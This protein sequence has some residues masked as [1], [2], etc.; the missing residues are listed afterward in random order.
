MARPA[1]SIP[2]PRWPKNKRYVKDVEK[3]TIINWQGW[4]GVMGGKGY[5]ERWDGEPIRLR[6]DDV[7]EILLPPKKRKK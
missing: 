3:G 1:I 4:W 7:V 2:V 5:F 6:N